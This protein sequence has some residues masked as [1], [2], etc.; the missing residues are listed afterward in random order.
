MTAFLRRVHPDL[1]VIALLTALVAFAL[2]AV[3]A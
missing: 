2:L 3:Y 1:L